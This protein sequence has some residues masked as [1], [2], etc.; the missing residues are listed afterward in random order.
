[1]DIFIVNAKSSV[2][3]KIS[4]EAKPLGSG[5]QADVHKIETLSYKKDYCVKKFKDINK[6]EADRIQYM[7]D[8]Q[9][10]G[11]ILNSGFKICWPVAMAYNL[12]KQPIGYMMPLAFPESRDLLILAKNGIG[13]AISEGYPKY[14]AWHNK[15]E[16]NSPKGLENRLKMM[17][18]W[19]IAMHCIHE[20]NRYVI[21]DIKPEN[22]LASPTGKISIVDTD[23]FQIY[24]GSKLLFEASAYTPEY[25]APDAKTFITNN[26]PIPQSCDI[27]SAAVVFYNIL[28]G[29]HPYVGIVIKPQYAT[30]LNGTTEDNISKGYFAYGSKGSNFSI[31]PNSPHNNFQNLSKDIQRL[32]RL[33]FDLNPKG[34]PNMEDFGKAFSLSANNSN[35]S[36]SNITQQVNKPLTQPSQVSVKTQTQV[37]STTSPIQQSINTQN[38]QQA[39]PAANSTIRNIFSNKSNII[40]A[41]AGIV[42][43]ALIV[44][45]FV[46]N[47]NQ[48]SDQQE[49]IEEQSKVEI[50]IAK[51]QEQISLPTKTINEKETPK[52]QKQQTPAQTKPIVTSG[53]LNLSGGT[54]VG[55]IKNGK[56]DG[57]GKMTYSSRTL[58]SKNDSKKRYAEAG[59][60]IEGTWKNG[61]LNVGNLFNSDG[62][63]V[64]LIMIGTSD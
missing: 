21:C 27:F 31:V 33:A 14:P 57:K 51:E 26:Q 8:N 6:V 30:T 55:S 11:I 36:K 16:L 2:F 46:K 61:E 17:V 20:T 53:T 28:V 54:Y 5:G 10:Q 34:R 42:I 9:P 3:E 43:I 60:Y 39:T 22:V 64:E 62:T 41:I 45:I 18:N 32:F 38:S 59:Q 7:I 50:S 58:I 19:A 4:L 40:I 49:T 23:S 29:I 25:L 1:M 12:K 63:K 37:T 52:S 35:Q 24:E 15:Y 47:N 44:V 56:A 48:V 13:K